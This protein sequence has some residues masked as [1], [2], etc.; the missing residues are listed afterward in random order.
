MAVATKAGWYS[1][2]PKKPC[3][4]GHYSHRNTWG[5]CA[6]CIREKGRNLPDRKERHAKWVEKNREH[7]NKW[8]RDYNKNNPIRKMVAAAKIRAKKL[9][10]PFDIDIKELTIPKICPVL[11][12]EIKFTGNKRTANS[13]SL[14]RI[15]PEKGYVKGNVVI[16]SWRANQLKNDASMT[17]MFLVAKFY[18]RMEGFIL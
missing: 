1:N 9:N 4:K 15:I 6:E 18:L 13:P 16:V 2:W 11:G 5:M 10:I 7:S 14:D 8:R 3:G 17:E 12:I